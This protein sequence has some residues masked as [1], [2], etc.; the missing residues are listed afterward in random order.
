M[1]DI[2]TFLKSINYDNIDELLDLNIDKVVLNKKSESF[3]VYLS[4]NIV[5]PFNIT[6]KLVDNTYLINNTYKTNIYIK[7]KEIKNEDLINYLKEIIND[8][9]SEKPSLVSLGESIPEIDDDIIIFEVISEAE[10]ETIK[11]EEN[12]I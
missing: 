7:Y 9:V 6:K 3:N 8:L 1:H 10:A 5:L 2:K 11:M 12:N 4:S